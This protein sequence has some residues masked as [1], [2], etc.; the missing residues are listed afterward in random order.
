MSLT[1]NEVYRGLSA[2]TA[3]GFYTLIQQVEVPFVVDGSVYMS[4]FVK[5]IVTTDSWDDETPEA[6]IFSVGDQF[7]KLDLNFDSWGSDGTID[8]WGVNEVK[9]VTKTVTAYRQV[10]YETEVTEYM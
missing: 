9:P 4:R 1:S 3:R 2:F 10:A 6:V 5:S 8:G 7:F